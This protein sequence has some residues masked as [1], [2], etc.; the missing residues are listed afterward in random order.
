M[1][2]L[3]IAVI[4]VPGYAVLILFAWGAF[5]QSAQADDTDEQIARQVADGHHLK[6]SQPEGE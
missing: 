6:P 1:D 2:W 5:I 4:L 3:S